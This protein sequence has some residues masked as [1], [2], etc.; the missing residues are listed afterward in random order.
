VSKVF[1]LVKDSMDVMVYMDFYEDAPELPER[2]YFYNVVGT[3]APQYL[4]RLIDQQT[5]LRVKDD[6][7]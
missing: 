4:R 5:Q 3:V 7:L 2:W 6:V 1:P